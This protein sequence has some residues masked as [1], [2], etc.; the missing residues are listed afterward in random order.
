MHLSTLTF[1]T[2]CRP[3]RGRL[4]SIST[5]QIEQIQSEQPDVVCLQG[6][7]IYQSRLQYYHATHDRYYWIEP[8]LRATRVWC[9]C[10]YVPLVGTA[11]LFCGLCPTWWFIWSWFLWLFIPDVIQRLVVARI[12]CQFHTA[13]PTTSVTPEAG[14]NWTGL[15]I[16]LR[17]DRFAE[18]NVAKQVCWPMSQ[19][20]STRWANYNQWFQHWSS[21]VPW[22]SPHAGMMI[23]R[24]KLKISQRCIPISI[25]NCYLRPISHHLQARQIRQVLAAQQIYGGRVTHCWC[26]GDLNMNHAQLKWVS[27]NQMYQW[28]DP[29]PLSV[30]TSYVIHSTSVFPTRVDHVTTRNQTGLCVQWSDCGI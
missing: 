20:N 6:L 28:A 9:W 17:K 13:R 11:L 21:P 3:W 1:N 24:A 19:S 25:G 15:V 18:W 2:G 26:I 27:D 7:M 10:W 22:C 14:I 12:Q 16:L 4:E 5:Q 29:S 30:G 8:D 23:T